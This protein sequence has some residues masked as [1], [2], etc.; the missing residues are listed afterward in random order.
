MSA[1]RIDVLADVP[2]AVLERIVSASMERMADFA[3][4]CEPYSSYTAAD[5]AAAVIAEPTGD[6]AYFLAGLI[7]KS[8]ELV[9]ALHF[10]EAA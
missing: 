3:T 1:K 8:T 6:V 5:I 2:T 7:A 10:S 9:W 4:R